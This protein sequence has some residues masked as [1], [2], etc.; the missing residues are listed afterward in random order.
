MHP[1]RRQFEE[2]SRVDQ[3]AISW[4]I[5]CQYQYHANIN[6]VGICRWHNLDVILTGIFLPLCEFK[7]VVFCWYHHRRQ[8]QHDDPN[9]LSS[10]SAWSKLMR[11]SQGGAGWKCDMCCTLSSWTRLSARMMMIMMIIVI[12]VIIMMMMI[13]IVMMMMIMVM[14]MMMTPVE[15]DSELDTCLCKRWAYTQVNRFGGDSIRRWTDK[16][17]TV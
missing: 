7:I 10:I 1:Q 4:L 11:R 15:K 14:I 9:W 8:Y 5:S 12:M 13:I 16:Q 3:T 2:E 6:K 17:K